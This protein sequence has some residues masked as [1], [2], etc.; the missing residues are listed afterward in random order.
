MRRHS[1]RHV[2]SLTHCVHYEY[3]IIP[4]VFFP[5]RSSPW[6][7]FP[8]FNAKLESSKLRWTHPARH[9]VARDL[10]FRDPMF[11]GEFIEALACHA[12]SHADGDAYDDATALLE[13]AI[14]IASSGDASSSPHHLGMFGVVHAYAALLR[15]PSC[16]D[17][18][19]SA[20][21]VYTGNLARPSWLS[22]RCW[23]DGDDR[24]AWL[25]LIRS[26]MEC[27]T[28]P[29]KAQASAKPRSLSL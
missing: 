8:T 25:L 19:I 3:Q 20:S 17:E 16:I 24:R 13:E 6:S 4:I 29:S 14:S 9:S 21:R 2:N 27:T 7:P 1:R 23:A 10:R 18:A 26:V 5:K 28:S 22:S 12:R 11:I 15:R